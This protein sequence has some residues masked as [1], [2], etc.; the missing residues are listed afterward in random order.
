MRA[1]ASF[2]ATLQNAASTVSDTRHDNTRRV[3][4]SITAVS[5]I[6]SLAAAW[7]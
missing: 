7:H 1:M 6:P 5:S 3:N 4:Q 2:T